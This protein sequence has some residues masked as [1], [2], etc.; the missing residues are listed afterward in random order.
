MWKFRPLGEGEPERSPHEAEFFNVGDLDASASLVR[1]A[2]QN[3]LDARLN[4]NKQVHVKFTLGSEPKKESNPYYSDLLSH[5]QSCGFKLDTANKDKFNFL[6][7]EDF[8]TKGLDGPIT[9]TEVSGGQKSNYYNLWWREGISQKEKSDAGRW[10]LGKTVFF[11]CSELRSFWGL[12]IRQDDSRELLLGKALLKSHRHKGTQ[13]DYYGYYC[14]GENQP[15]EDSSDIKKFKQQFNISRNGDK[16][17]SIVIPFPISDIT[18]QDIVRAVIQHYFYSI[19]SGLLTVEVKSDS[20]S[21]CLNKQNI[22]EIASK[23]NWKGTSWENHPV[24]NLLYFIHNAV[25]TQESE[26]VTL[27]KFALPKITEDLF[28]EKIESAQKLFAEGKIVPTKIPIQITL[29]N[30]TTIDSYFKTFIQKDEQLPKIEEFYIRS[31]I[32]ISEIKMVKTNNVRALLTAEDEPIAR[33]L[34]DSESP[35]HTD[36]KERTE[37]F[38]LK[39][40]NARDTLRYV[41]SSLREITRILDV[42]TVGIDPDFLK[43][44]FH[45]PRE[46]GEKL[47][48]EVNKPDVPELTQRPGIFSIRP[49]PGGFHIS[50][51]QKNSFEPFY[52]LIEVVY[53][54]KTGNPFNRYDPWDFIFDKSGHGYGKI[55][56]KVKGGKINKIVRNKMLISIESSKFELKTNGFDQNRDVVVSIKRVQ[57]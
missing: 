31:G 14:I 7:I 28:G 5:V 50:L 45:I 38:K 34:G 10:G 6:V 22:F 49:Q 20:D 29:P 30:N 25:N 47:G 54:T 27:D 52:A 26:F 51:A 53:D 19:I 3:S 18:Q 9:R 24:T 15:I 48:D 44:I 32:T 43:D 41:R 1:E 40:K 39:Y 56:P 35:A 23:S 36:W 16:G 46:Q 12:T 13:Y 21:T 11:V 2:I 33:F 57:A 4:S 17:L 37:D 8:G 42:P 55:V